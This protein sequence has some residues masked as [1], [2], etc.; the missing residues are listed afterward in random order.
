MLL[1]LT[2]AAAFA[3]LRTV[4]GRITDGGTGGPIPGVTVNVKGSNATV[5]TDAKG[6]YSI[7]VPSGA[8]VL[9]FSYVGYGTQEIPVGTSTTVSPSLSAAQRSMD[10]VVVIGYGRQSRRN[11]TGSIAK[12]NLAQTENLPNTSFAENLRGRVAGVQFIDNGR[13]GQGGSIQIRGQRSLSGLSDPLI[14]LDGVFFNGTYADINPNDVESIEVLKDVS[15]TAIY[16]TRAA[17][18]VILITT[19]KGRAAK[20][21]IRFN[22]YY[23]WSDWSHKVQLYSPDRYLQRILDYRRAN[24]Q[25]ANPDSIKYYLQTT[26]REMYEAGKT[27]DPWDAVSANNP[28][29]RS[30]DLSVSGRTDKTSYFMS[31]DITNEQGLIVND[32]AKRI[33]LRS[34]L[35]NKIADWLTLGL[36]AQFIR[37][38]L[39]G[40]RPPI[41]MAFWLSPYAKLFYDDAKTDPVPYPV[42]DQLEFNPLF[43]PT[44]YSNKALNYNLNGTMYAV[45]D[46]PFVKGLS[47]RLNYNPT[48][49]W[50]QN[51]SIQPRYDRAGAGYINIGNASRTNQQYSSWQ[52]E[53]IL[54]Y[55]KRLNDHDFDVTL[56]YGRDYN[57]FDITRATANNFFNTSLGYNN[58]SIGTTQ[59]APNGPNDA[60]ETRSISSMARLNYRY[61]GRYLL[62]LTARRDGSSVF[63]ENNKFG[64]F[65]SAALGWVLSDEGFMRKLE[66]VNLLKLRLS[67]GKV[68]NIANGPYQ[69]LGRFVSGQYVFGD[70]SATYTG[71]YSD[72]AFMPQL[73]LGW[74]TTTGANAGLDF[75]ILKSRI[76]GSFEWYQTKTTNLLQQ[77]TVSSVTGFTNQYVNLGQVNNSGFEITLNTVNVRTKKFEWSSNVVFSYNKNK[78]VHI[79]YQ[80]ANGD[81]IE[82]N[83]LVNGWFIGKPISVA[84]DYVFDGIYQAGDSM[85]AGYK[86]GWVRVKDISGPAGKPDGKITADDRT[87]IGQRDPKYRWG[88]TNTFRYGGF[89][90]SVFV[91]AMAGF[92]SNFDLLDVNT[93][94]LG[95]S[96]PGRPLNMFDGGYWTPENKS[97][98]RPGLNFTNPLG[99]RFYEKRDFVRLQDV[100]LAYDFPK[101][102]LGRYGVNNLRLYV[103]GKNLATVTDWEGPDPESGNRTITGLYPT[104]RTLTVGANLSF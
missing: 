51:Y 59:T 23:G 60:Q 48:F 22:T 55:A 26:E 103:S 63:G 29:I 57:Q 74:E 99:I 100:S 39:T 83:D 90:L 69:S 30:Y 7:G 75:E 86:P 56:L 95:Y 18:G 6:N 16:G 5:V 52:Y 101:T 21:T 43:A 102:F 92:I 64:T 87:I 15:A 93:Q 1:L 79:K 44:L 66:P 4:S 84:Y 17:N 11:V 40:V 81:G 20:P 12:V 70:G 65:P 94:A 3:Q 53:N 91:N 28:G 72:P 46:V 73:N 104:P 34:N 62:T 49:R 25:A 68:G 50:E 9:V 2:A 42:V 61:K 89:S 13:P 31:G 37:R 10:E 97:A 80:D 45:L 98:T 85:P 24:G 88:F 96:F 67:Y 41:E 78:I 35:E 32:V 27:V 82:D 19:K 38:N 33:S 71:V 14:I 58:L 47:Y 77:Q 54:T 36:N 8:A 76:G